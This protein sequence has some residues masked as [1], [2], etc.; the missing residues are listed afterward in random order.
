[1][2]VL[3]VFVCLQWQINIFHASCLVFVSLQKWVDLRFGISQRVGFA[4]RFFIRWYISL[5][6]FFL[7]P[8][9]HIFLSRFPKTC[10]VILFW[11]K[12][13]M[14][15]K[16]A[17]LQNIKRL[18]LMKPLTS[19]F[20]LILFLWSSNEKV[21]FFEIGNLDVCPPGEI[22][23]HKVLLI[24][25]KV[26]LIYPKVFKLGIYKTPSAIHIYS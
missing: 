23:F 18:V 25:Q 22:A 8:F 14:T 13:Q 7:F 17:V 15:F 6:F 16:W 4:F 10:L 3:F 2:S 21:G 1:M 20:F 5:S 19:T 24:Y 11:K 9:C 12:W 26:L